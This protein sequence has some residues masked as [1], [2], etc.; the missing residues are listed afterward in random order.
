MFVALS[1]DSIFFAFSF[2]SLHLPIWRVSFFSNKY[3]FGALAISIALLVSAVT[4]PPLQKLLSL[5]SLTINE[6]LILT[7]IGIFNLFV[8]EIAKYAVFERNEL[9]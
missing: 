1:L 3:L 5:T 8:I 4:M 6:I 7:G 9:G 2:K